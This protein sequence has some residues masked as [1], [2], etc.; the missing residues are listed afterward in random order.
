MFEKFPEKLRSRKL[1]LTLSAFLSAILVEVVGIDVQPDLIYGL[2]VAV[3]SYNIGQGL[4]DKAKATAEQG[5]LDYARNLQAEIEKIAQANQALA[6]E[7]IQLHNQ[8]AGGPAANTPEAHVPLA[9]YIASEGDYD[10]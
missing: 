5:V 10:L 9:D 2:V 7:N 8:L 4:V 6:Q 3:G 1:W